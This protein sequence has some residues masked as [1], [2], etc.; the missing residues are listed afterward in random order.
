DADAF[1]DPKLAYDKALFR[2]CSAELLALCYFR[3]G[4]YNDA[5]RL[6]RV[7]ARTSPDPAAC[8]LKARLAQLR[9]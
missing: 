9:M 3:S 6:Y 7:A 4:R 1:F 5:A 2:H 8:E